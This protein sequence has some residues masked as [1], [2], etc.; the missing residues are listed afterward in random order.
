MVSRCKSTVTSVICKA[1]TIGLWWRCETALRHYRLFGRY[2]P[3]GRPGE[4]AEGFRGTERGGSPEGRYEGRT[5][6]KSEGEKVIRRVVETLPSPLQRGQY[7][8]TLECGHKWSWPDALEPREAPVPAEV[9]CIHC[10]REAKQ[11]PIGSLAT[12]AQVRKPSAMIFDFAYG[13]KGTVQREGERVGV[14]W[15]GGNVI[16]EYPADTLVE[17]V[18]A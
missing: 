8:L 11:V 5:G 9:Y 4:G 1:T 2:R 16:V 6:Q 17:P 18:D 13:R 10:E 15:E 14:L 7:V 12:G 3:Q